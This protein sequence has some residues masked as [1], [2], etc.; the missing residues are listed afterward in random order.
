MVAAVDVG[1]LNLTR[2]EPPDPESW[3]FGQ[4]Q[5]GLEIRDFYGRLIDGSL[6]LPGRVRSGGDG[7]GLAMQASPPTEPLVAFFSGV[8]E[9]DEE[10]RAEIG[11]DIPQFNGTVRV[12]AVGWTE[13]GVGHASADVVVRDPIVV[14]ASL[15]RFL[16]PQDEAVLRLDIDNTDGPAGD[17]Q[18]TVESSGEIGVS[19]PL[20]GQ[21]VSLEQ[22]RRTAFAVPITG[23][24]VGLARLEVRL[25]SATGPSI[26]KV[27]TV[28]VRS[29]V[30]PV[31]ERKLVSLR[32]NGGGITLDADLLRG[33]K[34]DG[35]VLTAG[36]SRFA[37]LDV[38]SIL[39]ALDR[40]PYGCAEQ[41]TSKAL[42]LL[43]LSELSAASG[44][45]VDPAVRERV[46]GAI[47]RVLL[48]QSSSGSF[49]LWSPG[50][51]DLWLDGYVSEF[52]TRARELGYDVPDLA[53]TQALDN[54]A[55][56]LA[57]ETNVKERG[58]DIAYALYVLARNRRASIGDLRYYVDT[59]LD[60]FVSP[61]AKAQLAAA[62]ALYGETER[63]E[64]AFAAALV[65]LGQPG[66]RN[67]VRSDYG[68][69]LRDGAATLALAA[70]SK[71]APRQVPDLL[72][73]VSSGR[74]EQRAT[75]TQENAWTLLAARALKGAGGELRLEVDGAP[76][77][78]PFSIRR[79]AEALDG[80]PV[81]IVNRSDGDAQA[82]LTVTGVPEAPLPAGGEGF[83]IERSYYALDGAPVDPATVGQNERFV[84]VITV[85]EQNAWP[86]RVLVE[87]LLPAGFEIDNPRLVGSADLG[88][89]EFL[90]ETIAVAHSE[91]RDDRF[92][93][94][95]NREASDDRRFTLAYVVRAVTPGRYAHPAA[96]VED[97]YRPH[98]QARTAAGVV[99]V[100]G[101]R[102]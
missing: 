96:R 38:A 52:L 65:G 26:E 51:G 11:F 85:T 63:A 36:I 68:S 56:A 73:L 39:L 86:S 41:T 2:Y 8:V 29:P 27:L 60:E 19:I 78:G 69:W 4:R 99:E 95:L 5:M 22:G 34:R 53:L 55:N 88:A 18:L 45:E 30:Q 14:T 16:A 58:G 80:G 31:S 101:P 28:P 61:M 12:M 91:F 10:G 24:L 48:Y 82:V 77:A 71:P 97:M 17:Y 70:E 6:G 59:R 76:H 93:A 72:K 25:A 98:L 13:D 75:S 9:T 1:I 42:P 46:Q 87:D 94:A 84:V 37:G 62:L 32:G 50:D 90:P 44:L 43:Y 74:L 79:S 66:S 33:F 83:A 3:F 49:G 21:T 100:S 89:L 47:E 92:V 67:L 7:G 15:P 23:K 54:L 35:A 20:A 40:F 57:Y 64:T 81:V 102:P